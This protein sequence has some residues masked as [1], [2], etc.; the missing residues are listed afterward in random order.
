MTVP[1]F[2]ILL[3]PAYIKN[4]FQVG[5]HDRCVPQMSSNCDF[6]KKPVYGEKKTLPES[7]V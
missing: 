5:V 6:Y 1:E 7:A 4:I 2:A 3:I